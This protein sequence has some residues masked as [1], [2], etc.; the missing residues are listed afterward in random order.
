MQSNKVNKQKTSQMQPTWNV[1]EGNE[2]EM[3]KS[4]EIYN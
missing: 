1:Y 2:K 4:R 3:K